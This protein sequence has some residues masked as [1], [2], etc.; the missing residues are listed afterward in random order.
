[1]KETPDELFVNSDELMVEPFKVSLGPYKDKRSYVHVLIFERQ[2]G[3]VA[4]DR[5]GCKKYDWKPV[6][7]TTRALTRTWKPKPR[8]W[9]MGI[10]CLSKE[11]LRIS[12][13][14]HEFAHVAMEWM[15]F[16]WKKS[17]YVRRSPFKE[18]KDEE[19]FCQVL[20]DAVQT[21]FEKMGKRVRSRSYDP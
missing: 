6:G 10:M 1:M 13:V 2:K 15:R 17:P 11:D 14:V 5:Q 7:K 12:T 9:C 20:D 8:K 4:H 21:F 18:H 3:M 19:R 16:Y